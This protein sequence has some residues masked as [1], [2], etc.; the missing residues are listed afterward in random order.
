MTLCVS[1]TP[2]SAA[3]HPSHQLVRF[4]GVGGLAT[5]VQLGLFAALLL[6]L[7]Q[8]WANVI[9]WAASTLLANAAQRSVT[10]GV[11]SADSARL[12][13]AVSTAFSTLALATSWIALA[14]LSPT[15]PVLS[16]AVLLGVNTVVGLTRFVALRWWFSGPYSV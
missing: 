16:V 13:L 7:P 11:H 6:V 3:G 4:A 14:E 12:D 8:V 1:R 15:D 10:F 5:A 2:R 9:S